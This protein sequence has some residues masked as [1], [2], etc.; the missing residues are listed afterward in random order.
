MLSYAVFDSNVAQPFF[1]HGA[2]GVMRGAAVCFFGFTS[3]EQPITVA[4]EAL[5]PQRDL[6]KSLTRQILIETIQYSVLAYLV[7]GYI[8]FSLIQ[9][10]IMMPA[11]LLTKG[12]SNHAYIVLIGTLIGMFPT[13]LDS[14]LVS[15]FSTILILHI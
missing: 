2:K 3:F 11:S 15:A 6:P 8:D 10:D 7:S 13:V 4:E 14:L 12:L 1:L 9:P 5:N